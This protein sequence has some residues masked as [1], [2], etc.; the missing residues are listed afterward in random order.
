MRSMRVLS[1]SLSDSVLFIDFPLCPLEGAGTHVTEPRKK[2]AQGCSEAFQRG[3]L[4]MV[5]G[6]L[7]ACLS[8]RV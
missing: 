5:A 6:T 1:S 3:M 2:L 8:M 4:Q 7:T